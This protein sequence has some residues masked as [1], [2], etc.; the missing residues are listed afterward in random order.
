MTPGV[1]APGRTAATGDHGTGGA[2]A[3]W[4]ARALPLFLALILAAVAVAS[5]LIGARPTDPGDVLAALAAGPSGA[6]GAA[7]AAGPSDMGHIVWG[8]RVPR[9]ILAAAVGGA[10][11]LAGAVAQAWTRNPLADP[12]IIGV[13]SGAGFAVAVGMTAGFGHAAAKAPLALAGAAVAA[14]IVVGAS[15]ASA[16]PL[17]LIL[18]GV[19]VSAAAT[20]A[21]TLMALQSE[22]V[23]DG[24]RQW[25]VGSVSGRTGGDIALALGGLAVGGAVAAFAA[26]SMDLLAMGDDAAAGLGASPALIRAAMLAAVIVPAAAATAAVGPVAFVGFA[27]P[28]LLRPLTG[29]ALTRLLPA[30]AIAGAALSLAADVV[31]RMVMRPGEVEVSIILALI[32]APLFILAARKGVRHAAD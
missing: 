26:R 8:L 28:H 15:K 25:T 16:D 21:T 20:A 22:D 19:G 31:G 1:A 4:T 14:L 18:V 23:L 5:L 12:G 2:A 13:T 32:G 17:M 27:A 30:A 7:G 3:A 24:M 29:P 6:S 10:L 9:M 11:A